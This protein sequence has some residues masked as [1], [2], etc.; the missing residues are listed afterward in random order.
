MSHPASDARAVERNSGANGILRAGYVISGL[1][2]VSG[3]LYCPSTDIA[4][5]WPQLQRTEFNYPRPGCSRPGFNFV[6]GRKS[7]IPNSGLPLLQVHRLRVEPSFALK[8]MV[9]T[10]VGWS[11]KLM[12]Y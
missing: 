7:L 1:V 12:L 10:R 6:Y 3:F 9:L 2:A 8:A 4:I 5:A 11:M